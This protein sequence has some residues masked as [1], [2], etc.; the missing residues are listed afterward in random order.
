MAPSTGDLSQPSS[1]VVHC[2]WFKRDSVVSSDLICVGPNQ[3]YHF[4]HIEG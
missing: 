4:H 2:L 3:T 1:S